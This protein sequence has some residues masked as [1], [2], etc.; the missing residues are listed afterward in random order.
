MLERTFFA[1]KKRL[2]I[3]WYRIEF[4]RAKKRAGKTKKSKKTPE[5]QNK[6]KKSNGMVYLVLQK[7]VTGILVSGILL[8]AGIGATM[9]LMPQGRVI[10]FQ[11]IS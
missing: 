3:L 4:C 1:V 10:L 7:M 8:L 2:R 9:L 5:K 6:K 11:L